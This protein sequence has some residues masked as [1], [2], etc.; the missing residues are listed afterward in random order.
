MLLPHL[1]NCTLVDLL[2]I[3]ANIS[4][5][6]LNY[7][8][9]GGVTFET[10][11]DIDTWRVID[12]SSKVIEKKTM[13]R[14]FN[15]YKQNNYVQFDSDS[16]VGLTER[17]KINY[18]ID[19]QNLESENDLQIIEY[20]EAAI[21]SMEENVTYTPILIKNPD[22]QRTEKAT[23]CLAGQN[24]T[25]LGRI[26]LTK[27]QTIQDLCDESTAMDLSASMS[28]LEFSRI[29]P[30]TLFYYNGVKYVWTDAQYSKGV[31]TLKLSKINA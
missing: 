7:S 18:T 20:S 27:N 16:F 8:D 22:E 31:V 11:Q 5:N 6:V 13:Q 24:D 14:K 25:Y 4:G 2:K 10:L 12:L 28:L 29:V 19:N 17:I 3:C 21:G 23:I 15:D 30:K 9:S 1:P 26:Y